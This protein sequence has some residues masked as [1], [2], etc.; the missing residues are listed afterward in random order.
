MADSTPAPTTNGSAPQSTGAAISATTTV[1]TSGAGAIEF[2]RWAFM[3]FPMPPPES[4]L[5]TMAVATVPFVH[6]LGKGVLALVAK[7]FPSN[8]DGAVVQPQTVQPAP[9]P[10]TGQARPWPEK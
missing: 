8:G 10:A 7:W 3:G 1:A 5:M 2:Y 4:V 9:A 6:I